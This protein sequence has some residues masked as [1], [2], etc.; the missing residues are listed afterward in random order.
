MRS[1]TVKE[2]ASPVVPRMPSPS[3]PFWRSHRQWRAISGMLGFESP[4]T[5][6]RAAA[7]TPLKSFGLSVTARLLFGPIDD[8]GLDVEFGAFRDRA[9]PYRHP[10][11]V[12][13]FA[14]PRNERVP[15]GQI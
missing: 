2:F 6:V 14:I 7:R 4:V 15:R 11:P 12:H 1:F 8:A 9:P 10:R 5:G 13:R 3:Q